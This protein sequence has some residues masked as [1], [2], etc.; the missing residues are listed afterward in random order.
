MSY[1]SQFNHLSA[2]RRVIRYLAGTTDRG[3]RY[4]K[5]IEDAM[6]VTYVDDWAQ[7]PNEKRCYTGH[8]SMLCGGALTID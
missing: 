3:I 7:C 2:V 5:S 4:K 1:L 8:I 6:I